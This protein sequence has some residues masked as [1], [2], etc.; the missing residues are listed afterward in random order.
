MIT[1]FNKWVIK[2]PGLAYNLF[3]ITLLIALV[4]MV[5]TLSWPIEVYVV[6]GLIILFINRL[7]V[8]SV[9]AR[10]I[11]KAIKKLNYKCDPEPLYDITSFLIEHARSENE[12]QMLLLNKSVA[13]E[14]MGE[15]EKACEI[16]S[17]LIIDN[18]QSI[19]LQSK[20]IYHFNMLSIYIHLEDVEQAEIQ[21]SKA[22]EI[23]DQLSK[24]LKGRVESD[25]NLT[26]AE[27]RFL[28]GDY[29]GAMELIDKIHLTDV[30]GDLA[31]RLLRA[32]LNI[33]RNNLYIARS[34]LEYIVAKGNKLYIVEKA[35]KLLGELEK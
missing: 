10:E 14:T 34:D 12:L 28:K 22:M 23:Y 15:Y 7:M 26:I 3:N 4:V 1:K 11:N 6:V 31:F 16:L 27:F 19:P 2:H 29:E 33:H 32:R 25:V 21:Y 13:L 35:K 8:A 18:M 17:G 30:R 24:S 20:I 5:C 9:R